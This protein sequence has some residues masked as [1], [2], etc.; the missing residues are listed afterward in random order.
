MSVKSRVYLLPFLWVE[1]RRVWVAG[2]KPW[3]IMFGTQRVN[4]PVIECYCQPSF[5]NWT[6]MHGDKRDYRITHW[7]IS[8]RLFGKRLAC[9]Q[10]W[11]TTAAY[12]QHD[13]D[14]SR[15]TGCR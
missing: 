12:A 11:R 10:S 1:R 14:S 2:N 6:K 4:W 13:F 15:W 3:A 7:S 8:L 9:S 5:E